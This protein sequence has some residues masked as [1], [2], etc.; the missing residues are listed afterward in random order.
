MND[1]RM[2]KSYFNKAILLFGLFRKHRIN[3][4]DLATA[5]SKSVYLDEKVDE[6]RLLISMGK[7]VFAGRYRMNKWNLSIITATIAYVISPLDAM[8]D[9]IP[10]MGW[11]DDATIVAYAASKL[12]DE[13]NKYKAFTQASVPA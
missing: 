8:P 6:F 3:G 9:M 12:T 5:E 10:L 13:I 7:D 1:R 11:M 4:D 2:K